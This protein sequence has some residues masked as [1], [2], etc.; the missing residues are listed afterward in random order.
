[1][2]RS[3]TH[4][5]GVEGS[6]QRKAM[7]RSASPGHSMR[8]KGYKQLVYTSSS[9][10]CN[11]QGLLNFKEGAALLHPISGYTNIQYFSLTSL[12]TQFPCSFTAH[13]AL[14]SMHIVQCTVWNSAS[15]TLHNR[16]IC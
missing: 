1:M 14:L 4:T 5:E 13:I 8:Y 12:F 2:Y 7:P 3:T 10:E 9:L 15:V 6:A 11:I 16:C